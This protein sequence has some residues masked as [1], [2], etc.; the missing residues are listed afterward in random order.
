MTILIT[1]KITKTTDENR[2][3][4][5]KILKDKRGL[6]RRMYEDKGEQCNGKTR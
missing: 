6:G 2:P 1:I 4:N 5:C 3:P